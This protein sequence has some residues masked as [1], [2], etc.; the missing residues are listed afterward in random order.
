MRVVSFEARRAA[1]MASLIERH[2][3]LAISAPAMR[4][5][6]ANAAEPEALALA[7]ALKAG[8]ID[9][10]VL[11]T[12]VGTRALAAAMAPELPPEALRQL[13]A[14]QGGATTVVVR[15]PKPAAALR[16]LGVGSWLTVPEPNTWQEVLSTLEAAGL[17]TKRVAIQEHG[18]P[19]DELRSRL[20]GAGARVTTVKVYRWALPED[21]APLRKGLRELVDGL[22]HVALFTSRA[23]VEHA[24]EFAR[25]QG[26]DAGVRAGLA[27]AV[28]GSIGP[29]CSQALRSE[30][31]EVDLEPSH[32]KMGHLVKETAARAAEL[33]RTKGF[34]G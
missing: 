4:E 16:E 14:D 18:V 1:E 2:G 5:V 12:G 32:P 21:T 22:A 31:I 23:Q 3:G 8:E 10:L 17:A 24:L 19:S 26:F 29:V 7:R 25:E 30:G 27:R 15:G 13:L 20:E 9:V 34:G 28:I 33:S 11:M 6:A